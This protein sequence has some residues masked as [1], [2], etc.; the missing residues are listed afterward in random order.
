MMGTFWST[1][2]LVISS[3]S[4]RTVMENNDPSKFKYFKVG[5][6][7]LDFEGSHWDKRKFRIASFFGEKYC[8]LCL[9][10]F[11]GREECWATH[12]NLC[13]KDIILI[14]ARRRPYERV[15]DPLLV[16]LIKTGN[17]E[18]KREFIIRSNRKKYAHRLT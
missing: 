17:L 15:P 3:E 12:S 16:K 10:Y 11:A 9:A 14:G 13:V 2:L 7:V 4:N 8:P 5:D 1:E 6:I 18:A